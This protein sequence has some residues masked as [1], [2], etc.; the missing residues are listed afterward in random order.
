MMLNIIITILSELNILSLIL[1]IIYNN[2]II[3]VKYTLHDVKYHNNN[4]IRVKY[5]LHDVKYHNIYIPE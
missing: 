2:N 5:T 4:I 1:N 3:R